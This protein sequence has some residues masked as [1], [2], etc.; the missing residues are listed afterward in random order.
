MLRD[1]QRNEAYRNAI[2]SNREYFK[3]KTVLDVGAG[4][5]MFENYIVSSYLQL[6]FECCLSMTVFRYFIHIVC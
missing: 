3:N 6:I 1:V 4:T 2:E 5:G